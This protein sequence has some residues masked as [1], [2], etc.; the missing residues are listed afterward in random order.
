MRSASMAAQAQHFGG[1]LAQHDDAYVSFAV[2]R[3]SFPRL[4][5]TGNQA[6]HSRTGQ[7]YAGGPFQDSRH[8]DGELRDE[9]S[10]LLGGAPSHS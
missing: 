5:L 7:R 2:R 1:R 3:N 6:P 10:P 4:T 8:F 9:I